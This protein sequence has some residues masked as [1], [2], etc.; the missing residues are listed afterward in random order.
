MKTG[1]NGST[2]TQVDTDCITFID[3]LYSSNK[4]K[5]EILKKDGKVWMR[6]PADKELRSRFINTMRQKI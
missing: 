6:L 1:R 2:A 5:I 3:R 4:S